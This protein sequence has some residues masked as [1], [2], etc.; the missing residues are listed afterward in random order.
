MTSAGGPILMEP[1][2]LAIIKKIRQARQRGLPVFFTLDAG[3][4][5]HLLYPDKDREP[6]ESFIR[7]ELIQYCENGQV[8]FD[9]CGE[10]PQKFKNP[11]G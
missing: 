9:Q 11:L 3:P 5:V 6:V 7:E 4:N 2:S 8:I 1:G 10:G